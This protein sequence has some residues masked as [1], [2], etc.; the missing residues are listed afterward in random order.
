[1]TFLTHLITLV[2][3]LPFGAVTIDALGFAD[4]IVLIADCPCKLQSILDICSK[5]AKENGMSFNTSKCKVMPLNGANTQARFTMDGTVLDFVSTYKYLGVSLTSKYVTSLFKDHFQT[6]LVK[7]KNRAAAIKGLGFSKN[8]FRVETLL[9]LYKLQVRPLLELCAQSLHYER[10]SKPSQPNVVGGFAKKFEHHQTQQLK[11]LINSPRSTSPSIVRLFCGT[12]PITCRLE[13]IKLRYFWRTLHGPTD[14]LSYKI[15][16]QRRENFFDSSRGFARDVFNICAKYNIMHIWNALPP[17]GRLNLRLNVL[18]YI[19]R[20]ITSQ[21]LR[22]DLEDGRARNC[23]FTKNFLINPFCYQKKYHIVHPFRQAN[24]FSSANG[25]KRFIKALL[26]PGT[27]LDSCP[28]C[29]EHTNDICEHM[30]TKCTRIPDPREKL[31][32][33]LILYDYP[34]THF[35]LTKTT[36]IEHSLTNRLWRK[37]F[38]EF[39]TEVDF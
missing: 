37:C 4:D 9:R 8:G 5:W 19:K 31:R 36:I 24:C 38:A 26:H 39:L 12:E 22:K 32:R 16:K 1:M 2:L 14:S 11:T 6:I 33:K 7:A 3:G 34:Q 21:N 27:Y 20:I 23:C 28:L 15:L 29:G 35:P 17:P 18:H 13:F 10:Y 25:R 30:L